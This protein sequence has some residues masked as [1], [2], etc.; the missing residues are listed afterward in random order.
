[1]STRSSSKAKK[2]NLQVVQNDQVT[3]YPPRMS[4]EDEPAIIFTDE[5]ARRLHHPHDD[6]I[7][8]TLANANYTT[9]RVLIDNGS[10]TD[11]LYYPAFQQMRIN[12][13]LLRPVSVPLINFGG[14]KVLL[15]GTISLPVVVGSYPR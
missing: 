10:S 14:M 1:M 9:R 3:G 6:A 4:R 7:V 8:I 15:V 5:D 2:T 13:E 11:I 12:K